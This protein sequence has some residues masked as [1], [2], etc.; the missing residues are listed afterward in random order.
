[1][2]AP[3]DIDAMSDVFRAECATLTRGASRFVDAHVD[4]PTSE[5]AKVFKIAADHVGN[6]GAAD[7]AEIGRRVR[8]LV[9]EPAWRRAA[10]ERA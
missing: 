7:D 9:V 8:E 4:D 10:M 1:M 3:A 2:S 5:L 6:L